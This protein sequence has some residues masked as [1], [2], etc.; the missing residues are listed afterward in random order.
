MDEVTMSRIFEP[1]FTT[2]PVGQGTGLGLSTVYGIVKQNQGFINVYSEPGEGST[3][4]IYLPRH[5]GAGT[6]GA[7]TAPP[8]EPPIGTERV[9]LV[10]DE[11][12][13]LKLATRQLE[14]LGYSVL[15]ASDADEAIGIAAAYP[16]PIHLLLTDVVMPGMNG[17]DLYGRL[18]AGRPDLRCLFVSGYTAAGIAHRG[19]LE[20][21]VHFL[22]KP[23]TVRELAAASREAL[24]E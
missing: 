24:S 3:F 23:F 10:E 14:S 7:V 8:Q 22:Q 17:P 20:E 5:V 6:A 13:I 2:K 18:L 12:S 21:G 1:F 19:V 9:L 11:A 15:P 16:G 4:R